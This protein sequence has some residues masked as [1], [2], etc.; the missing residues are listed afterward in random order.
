VS[1]FYIRVLTCWITKGW[2]KTTWVKFSASL[3]ASTNQIWFWM[4]YNWSIGDKI[5][6]SMSGKIIK[7]SSK[8]RTVRWKHAYAKWVGWAS[9]VGD[10]RQK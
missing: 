8:Q 1:L 9:E 6:K 3:V 4:F 2:R 7:K 10:R 5:I